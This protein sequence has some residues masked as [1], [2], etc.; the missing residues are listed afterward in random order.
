MSWQS[1]TANGSPRTSGFGGNADS[2]DI[3][4]DGDR[5]VMVTPVD[6]D[7]ANCNSGRYALV[8]NDGT[9]HFADPWGPNQPWHT[10][11]HDAVQFDIDN[12]GCDD[13]FQGLC[14]GWKVF[15]QTDG[16]CD[17]GCYADFD[18]DGNLTILDFVAYQIAFTSGDPNAD[19]DGDGDLTILD[20]VCFQ[21]AF[22][23]G[24]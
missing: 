20:F 15:I 3:D 24:C 18:G 2:V 14:T 10:F 8:E 16:N 12:D 9:G 22:Q 6:V 19:C 17:P 7:I 11:A 13:I 4:N 21:T 1:F 23:E 5:D